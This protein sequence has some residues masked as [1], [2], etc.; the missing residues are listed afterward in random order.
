M[1]GHELSVKDWRQNFVQKARDAFEPG[2]GFEDGENGPY[3]VGPG[4]WASMLDLIYSE[5]SPLAWKLLD[6]VWP[7]S[8]TGKAKFLSDFCS[9]LSRSAYWPDL[10]PTVSETPEPCRVA[11]SEPV[12]K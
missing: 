2:E 12:K 8:K 4:L 5:R 9:Q 7:P 11:W 3:V 6:E 10:K 1:Q